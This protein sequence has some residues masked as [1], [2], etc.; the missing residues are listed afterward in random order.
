MLFLSPH[1]V[2]ETMSKNKTN[3]SKIQNREIHES[4]G[5]NT[6]DNQNKQLADPQTVEEKPPLITYQKDTLAESN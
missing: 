5:N 4:I 1:I 2:L 6:F 3:T